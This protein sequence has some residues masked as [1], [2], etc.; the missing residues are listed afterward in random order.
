[1]D[2]GKTFEQFDWDAS[3]TFGRELMRLIG[4]E[5]LII[6]DFGL[7]LLTDAQATDFYDV[8]VERYRSASTVVTGNRAIHEWMALFDDLIMANS[9]LERL[10]HQLVMEGDSYRRNKEAQRTKKAQD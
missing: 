5:L 8:V 2:L 1:M 9:A 7:Q 10:V 4:P 6:D 3:I